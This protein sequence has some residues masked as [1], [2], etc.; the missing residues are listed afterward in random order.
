MVQ[1]IVNYT[2]LLSIRP[3]HFNSTMVQL[4]GLVIIPWILFMSHF[5]S[6]M[7]QLIVFGLLLLKLFSL[8]SILLWFN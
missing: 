7:V 3:T 1:L 8:I 6:T 5:N 4:I 2:L